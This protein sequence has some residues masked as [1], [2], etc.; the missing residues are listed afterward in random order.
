MYWE[1]SKQ[2]NCSVL[3]SLKYNCGEIRVLGGMMEFL[4]CYCLLSYYQVHNF[5]KSSTISSL[6][7]AGILGYS[8]LFFFFPFLVPGSE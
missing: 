8:I 4:M 1:T 6:V 2:S 5:I 3:L 7:L